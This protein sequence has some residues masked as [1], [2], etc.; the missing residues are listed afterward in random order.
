M[1]KL[2]AT[3]FITLDGIVQAPGGPEEDTSG[4]FI[5]GGWVVPFFD[6]MMEKLIAEWTASAGALLLG[7]KTYEIFARHWPNVTD[8]TDPVATKLNSVRK[9]VASRTLDKVAWNNSTLIDGDIAEEV[10]KIKNEPGQEIQVHGS[11]ALLQTLLK[12]ELIDEFR[13]WVFPVLLGSGKRLFSEGTVPAR[14]KLIDTKTSST[15][16]VIHTYQGAEAPD[17]GS[18]AVTAPKT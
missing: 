2:I 3:T 8:D 10:I 5:H 4:G 13:L 15:G 14:L 11:G 6:E 7:R 17:Y 12:H 18:F 1:K 16:V 9:Y